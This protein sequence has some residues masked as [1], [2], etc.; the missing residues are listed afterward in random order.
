MLTYHDCRNPLT[1]TVHRFDDEIVI[2]IY[3]Q[4]IH[5]N[6]WKIRTMR[7]LTA[8][9]AYDRR[10]QDFKRRR[11]KRSS[12]RSAEMIGLRTLMISSKLPRR[13]WT[14]PLQKARPILRGPSV[15]LRNMDRVATWRHTNSKDVNHGML[16]KVH[17]DNTIMRSQQRQQTD[18]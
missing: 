8:G 17:Q 16:G 4:E 13:I 2:L 10:P 5:L 9:S 14:V 7:K 18:Q 11:W 12:A 15:G 3:E 6:Q 1:I